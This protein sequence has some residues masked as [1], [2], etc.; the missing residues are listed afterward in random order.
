MSSLQQ[1]IDAR[2]ASEPVDLLCVVVA[3]QVPAVLVCAWS[4]NCWVFPWSCLLG[5][6][7]RDAEGQEILALSFSAQQV[8]ARGY[9]LR[10]VL[11][12]IAGFR[13][14]CLR[15]LPPEYRR[16]FAADAPFIGQLEVSPE[17]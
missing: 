10:R 14:A 8:I 4:G 3:S 5:G 17:K 11:D 16:H 2:R 13:V 6:S 7:L 12:D 15:E 1:S 9:N